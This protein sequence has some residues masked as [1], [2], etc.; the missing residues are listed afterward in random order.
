M[1]PRTLVFDVNETLLDLAALDP[2]FEAYFTDADRR[3][4]WFAQVL[5]WSMVTTLTGDRR[6]F[7]ELAMASLHTLAEQAGQSLGDADQAR[8]KEAILTLPPHTDVAPALTRLATAGY[9]L[10]ALTNSDQA[11]VDAQLTNAGLTD[12]FEEILSVERVGRFKP[13]PAVYRMAA[14]TLALAPSQLLMVAAHDWDITG[15]MRAGYAGAYIARQEPVCHRA[16]EPPDLVARDLG[17]LADQLIQV[18]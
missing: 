9:T 10:V 3:H 18:S 4:E 5:R 12:H 6:G 13:H 8:F 7:S 15:A 11:A 14:D 2:L 17:H 1:M 16:G